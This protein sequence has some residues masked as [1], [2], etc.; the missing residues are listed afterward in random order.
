MS[1]SWA[2]ASNTRRAGSGPLIDPTDGHGGLSVRLDERHH[3]DIEVGE[4]E[5]WVVARIGSVRLVVAT[6]P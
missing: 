2:A 4:G 3:Y 1:C 6:R 5:V